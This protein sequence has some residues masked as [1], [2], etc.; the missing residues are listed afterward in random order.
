MALDS[1]FSTPI[2]P[3]PPKSAN[4]AASGSSGPGNGPG[5]SAG[6]G[7]GSSTAIGAGKS[8][9][10]GSKANASDNSTSNAAAT[11]SSSGS[12]KSTSKD[13]GS[14]ASTASGKANS[15]AGSRSK[16]GASQTQSSSANAAGSAATR[17]AGAKNA[18]NAQQDNNGA[19]ASFLQAL[20]QTQADAAQSVDAAATA[21]PEEVTGATGKDK[22]AN[23][24]DS[25]VSA[26]SLAFISQSLAA[27]IAGVQ[28]PNTPQAMAAGADSA[29]GESDPAGA[30]S[31]AGGGVGAL[32]N[33]VA[34]LAKDTAS[35]LKATADATSLASGSKSDTAT[36]GASGIDDAS[37]AVSAF[38]AH[39]SVGSHF[40]QAGATDP[41]PNRID[42]QVGSPAF[43]DELGGKVTWLANQGIQSA[44]LQLSPEHLGPVNVHI[45]VQD[46]SASVSFNA[47]HADTRAALEQALPRLRE[48]FA[49]HGL[50]LSDANVSQQSP[51]GQSQRQ[52]I[53]AIGGV[54]GVSDDTTSSSVA[55]VVS[56]R[57]GLL[58][59]YA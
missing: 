27:A 55:T 24:D 11:S 25:D 23:T 59:T 17:K 18:A 31:P 5:S 54:G 38:Q 35:G 33:L 58:D 41:N 3:P 40:Q 28:Q 9:G 42:A 21:A 26:S 13:Q 12:G 37:A 2:I 48:M 47:A 1:I 19:P 29:E 16:Q 45:S 43:N 22:T 8:D 30:I 39:M 50:T 10:F 20:A 34:S 7:S 44:S 15:A 51:G 6:A 56:S 52:S 36:G 32:Q 4:P 49:T 57:S 53:S 46:G 14:R